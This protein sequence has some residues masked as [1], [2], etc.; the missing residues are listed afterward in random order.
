MKNQQTYQVQPQQRNLTADGNVTPPVGGA[1]P[2]APPAGTTPPVTKPDAQPGA[3]ANGTAG[4]APE[5]LNFD[6]KSFQ[7]RLDR[8]AR[9]VLSGLGFDSPEAAKAAREKLAA[10]EKSEEDRKLAEMTEIDRLKAQLAQKDAAEVSARTAL[11]AEQFTV[12][13]ERA[14]ASKGAKNTGYA[15][16]LVEQARAAANGADVDVDA[17][18]DAA[19]KDDSSKAALGIASAPP[20]VKTG[21][22]STPTGNGGA[23]PTPPAPGSANGLKSVKD[24]TPDEYTVWK[25]SMGLMA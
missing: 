22:T 2:P 20:V 14:C 19:L 9:T 15:R 3:G 25:R 1:A 12:K 10:L 17:L 21:A 4:D 6:T 13:L 5:S 16:F 18:L 24:M 7:A 8:H 23:A 11:A